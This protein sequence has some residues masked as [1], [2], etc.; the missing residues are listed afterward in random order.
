MMA[1]NNCP[2][3]I[4]LD[5]RD[6]FLGDYSASLLTASIS[7]G[8]MSNL[9]VLHLEGNNLTP[10]GSNPKIIKLIQNVKQDIKILVSKITNIKDGMEKQGALFFGSKEEKQVIIKNI[11]KQSQENGV[12]VKNVTVSKDIFEALGNFGS[13]SKNFSYGWTKCTLVPNSVKSYVGDKII[14]KASPLA[15]QINTAIEM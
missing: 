11:L 13:L 1:S 9:K 8:E 6:N 12:D 14:A 10:L 5:L 2:N 4:Y 7:K 15:G 3:L